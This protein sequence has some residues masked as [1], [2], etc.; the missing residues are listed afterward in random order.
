MTILNA[1]TVD[2]VAS[3]YA[4]VVLNFLFESFSPTF[5]RPRSHRPWPF[6]VRGNAAFQLE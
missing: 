1:L 4:R 2:R 3:R 6:L 5:E